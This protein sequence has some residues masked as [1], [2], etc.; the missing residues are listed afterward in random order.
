M[1]IQIEGILKIGRAFLRTKLTSLRHEKTETKNIEFFEKFTDEVASVL[2]SYVTAR[3]KVQIDPDF[4]PSGKA[5]RLADIDAEYQPR[6]A[7]FQRRFG[8]IKEMFATEAE[9]YRVKP[10]QGSG[11]PILDELRGQE[12]RRH[13][14]EMKPEGR[15][16]FLLNPHQNPIVLWAVEN[17]PVPIEDIGVELIA[18][19]KGLQQATLNPEGM[20]ALEDQETVL[21]AIS[22]NLAEASKLFES[23]PDIQ[24]LE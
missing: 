2:K 20:L 18:R 14:A 24:I 4:S 6:M 23:P 8:N 11:N 3:E 9:Q 5:K 15:L 10:F 19:A 12:V 21:E 16:D 1:S 22:Y 13:L 7:D 17:S